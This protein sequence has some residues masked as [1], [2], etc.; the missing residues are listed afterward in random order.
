MLRELTI[1]PEYRDWQWNLVQRLRGPLESIY[2]AVPD[3]VACVRAM[4]EGAGETSPIAS[5][6]A[7]G[8]RVTVESA[9]LHGPR[10]QVRFS[11]GG[12]GKQRELADLLVLGSFVE[13]GSLLWQRACF[14]QAKREHSGALRSP[15]RFD[16]D[17]W[18]LAL[19]RAFPKFVGVSGA[20]KGI[21]CQLRNQS[22]MLGGYGLL[23]APGDF[24]VISARI[25]HIILGGRKSFAGKELIPAVVSEGREMH[26]RS[27]GPIFPWWPFDPDHCPECRMVFEH[28][29]GVPWGDEFWHHLHRHPVTAVEHHRFGQEPGRS[30]LTCLGLDEFVEDWTSLQ[31]GEVWRA[32]SNVPSDRALQT[33]IFALVSRVGTATRSLRHLQALMSR[34]SDAQPTDRAK[35][36]KGLHDEPPGGLAILSAVATAGGE[37]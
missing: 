9:F 6:Q 34:S 33:A 22:G 31:L 35:E 24:L 36:V 11:V 4:V 13:K 32:G 5:S 21:S 20:F 23:T 8:I 16:V 19:L 2:A 25:L 10:S 37:G 15:T 18:Q 3:E 7:P 29:W 12:T 27:G 26:V 14:I 17:E 1:T 28:Y 30:R